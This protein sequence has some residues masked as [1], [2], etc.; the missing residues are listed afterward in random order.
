MWTSDDT[1]F[2]N[3][4]PDWGVPGVSC[5]DP[6]LDVDCIT[7]CTVENIRLNQLEN[8]D[9][10]IIVHY[11]SDH[12]L[13]PTSPRVTVW[14]QGNQFVYGPTQI[15]DNQNWNVATIQWPT[16]AIIPQDSVLIHTSTPEGLD[17]LPEK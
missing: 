10:T 8:G 14:V 2:G 17:T 7:Q 16:L 13:G 3:L 6:T 9:Y 15:T 4:N 12:D 5:D 11:Y 1:Y